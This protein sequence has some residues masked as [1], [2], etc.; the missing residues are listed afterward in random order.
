MNSVGRLASAALT[1]IALTGGAMADG[2][3]AT[4]TGIPTVKDGDGL[5]FGKVEIRLQGVAAPEWSRYSGYDPVGEEAKDAL[6]RLV[7]G[8]EVVCHLDGTRA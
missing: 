3:A 5:L 6:A 4:L 7:D 8:Q 1:A 2:I